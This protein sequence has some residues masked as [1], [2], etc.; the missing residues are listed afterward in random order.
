MS[1]ASSAVTYTSVYTDSE[2]GRVFWGAD[3]ENRKRTS[4]QQ[5]KEHKVIRAYIAGPSN[6]KGF[7]GYHYVTSASFNTLV[8]ERQNV[9]I[10][11]GLVIKLEIVGPRSRERSKGPQWQNRKLKLPVMSVEGKNITRMVVQKGKTRG[12][13]SVMANNVNV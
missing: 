5:K 2:P 10:A 13:S 12:D 8:R 7:A 6:K 3:E 1:S 11:S 9:A 4:Q